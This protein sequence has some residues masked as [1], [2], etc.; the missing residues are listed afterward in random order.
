MLNAA[1]ADGFERFFALGT[2]V[3]R[4]GVA[5]MVLK[6]SLLIKR[7]RLR[8][9]VIGDHGNGALFSNRC[10]AVMQ[11]RLKCEAKKCEEPED[12]T[13]CYESGNK[14]KHQKN[15]SLLKKHRALECAITT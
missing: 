13:F 14:W 6:S 7:T 15:P 4:I 12:L 9:D 11:K 5:D 3:C 1:V 2:L 8:D 10:A